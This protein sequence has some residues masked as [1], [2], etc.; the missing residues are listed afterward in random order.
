MQELTIL[1]VTVPPQWWLNFLRANQDPDMQD[2]NKLLQKFQAVYVLDY[3]FKPLHQVYF[4][5]QDELIRFKMC[6]G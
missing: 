1:D 3:S 4:F 5:N 2:I 6:Y